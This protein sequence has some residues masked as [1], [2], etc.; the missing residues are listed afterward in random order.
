[1]V[2]VEAGAAKLPL[3]HLRRGMKLADEHRLG[4]VGDLRVAHDDGEVGLGFVSRLHQ[5][6]GPVVPVPLLAL[7][8]VVCA[9]AWHHQTGIA[10]SVAKG[11]NQTVSSITAFTTHRV[12]ILAFGTRVALAPPC[13]PTI[14]CGPDLLAA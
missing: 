1:M 10:P 9:V 11:M 2:F 5:A 8:H 4:F 13:P 14:P 6:Q 12:E 7:W 3:G